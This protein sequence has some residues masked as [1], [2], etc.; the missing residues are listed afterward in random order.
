MSSDGARDIARESFANKDWAAAY[1]GFS[2]LDREASLVLD[3]LE[4]LALCAYLIG[5]D[6]ES[7]DV[8]T[9]AHQ[10]CLRRGDVARAARC[11]F[12]LALILRMGGQMA[13]AGGWLGRAK[14]LLEEGDRRDCVEWGYLLVP[15]GFMLL[16]QDDPAGALELFDEAIATANTFDD[17]DLL[18]LGRLGKGEVMILA[19]DTAGGVALHDELMVAVTSGEISPVAAGL[20]YCSVIAICYQICDLRRAREWTAALTRWCEGQPNLV[21]YRGQCLVHRAELQRLRGAWPDAMEEAEHA[22]VQLSDPPGNPAIGEAFY[23]LAELH[24]LKGDF[25]RAEEAYREAGRAGRSTQ[26]G[27]AVLRLAQGQVGAAEAAIRL[28]LAGTAV[29]VTR[30]RLLAAAVDILLAADELVSAREV[31]DELAVIAHSRGVPFLDAESAHATG[32]VLLKEG[33]PSG[34][35]DQLRGALGAWRQVEAPY[36]AARTRVLVGLACRE[37]GDE[38]SA[39]LELDAAREAFRTL[40]AAPDLERVERLSQKATP[41]LAGGLTGREVQVLALIATGST[42]RMIATQ[43]VISEKTVARHVS[44]IFA[45]LGVS[46]RSAATAYAYEHDLV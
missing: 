24:R 11:A 21:P 37:L 28:E 10:E 22:R 18:T 27:L 13:P 33:D 17:A 5:R 29:H 12:W 2:A 43:L 35:L 34:A 14:R 20:A 6:E 16:A 30:A 19:G 42:N 26:P 39:Q 41:T 1:D 44:N 46:S 45:K 25:A 15:D 7:V 38:G 31:A 32:A 40:G 8:W 23:E 4:R 36:E 3:D 9:R